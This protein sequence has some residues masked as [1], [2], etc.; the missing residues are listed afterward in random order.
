MRVK[1]TKQAVHYKDASS[2]LIKFEPDKRYRPLC[3]ACGQVAANVHSHGYRRFIRDL[4]MANA[5]TLLQIEYR[6]V[7][8]ENCQGAR[9]EKFEFADASKRTTNRLARYIYDLCKVMTVKD[10]H[11]I[12]IV[13]SLY[14]QSKFSKV[15]TLHQTLAQLKVENLF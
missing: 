9:V 8:C 4:N 1:I 6:K 3:H 2:A 15:D 11:T 12:K 10:I 14:E 7:W 13:Y 5:Q